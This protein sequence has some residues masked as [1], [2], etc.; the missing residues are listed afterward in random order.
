[1]TNNERPKFQEL[2]HNPG[3]IQE[4]NGWPKWKTS[5]G[6][7][8]LSL[9]ILPVVH[10][11]KEDIGIASFVVMEQ[12]QSFLDHVGALMA[13]SIYDHFPTGSYLLLT[14][15]SKGSH[16]VPRVWDH[17]SNISSNDAMFSR[18]ITLRKGKPKVYMNRPVHKEGKVIG[19]PQ[20][21]YQSITSVSD[22]IL[23]VTPSDAELLFRIQEQHPHV[24]IVDD[25]IGK[26]GT[27]VAIYELFQKLGLTPPEAV[28][29]VGSDG[30][31][32]TKT[33]MEKG[34]GITV[35]PHIFPLQLPTFVRAGSRGEWRVK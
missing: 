35:L 13:K 7:F 19:L 8:R 15:E 27:V 29:V 28:A 25:F 18:I 22:Q 2:S 23:N 26:G 24:I 21:E 33:F 3:E 6:P 5:V 12:E 34:I 1:M 30:D 16:L 20:I 4:I 10:T 9:D 14:V 31:F 11:E 32:Y 17:L